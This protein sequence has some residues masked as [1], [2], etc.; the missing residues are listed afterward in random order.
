M[1]VA[2]LHEV[3]GGTHEHAQQVAGRLEQ[4]GNMP[5][6]GGLFHAE[7]S[8]D[9]GWWGFDIWESDEHAR[10]FYDG[11]LMPMLQ[12]LGIGE[13]NIRR[14]EVHWHSNQPMGEG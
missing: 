13:T 1:A 7:G 6:T 14:L 10:E 3:P 4:Q 8:M 9:G 2:Y 12:E 5:P 11:R